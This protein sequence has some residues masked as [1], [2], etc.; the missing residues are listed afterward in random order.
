MLS[1]K[2]LVHHR[3]ICCYRHSL[4]VAVVSLALAERFLRRFDRR[5]LVRGALLHD[6]FLYA[7]GPDSD[8]KRHGTTHAKVAAKNASADFTLSP[9]E[10]DIIKRHMFPL[11][12]APPRYRESVVVSLADKICAVGEFLGIRPFIT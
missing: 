6:Y 10:E 2:R 7:R 11:N 4:N 12:P 8:I 3:R 5:A 1:E 9:I